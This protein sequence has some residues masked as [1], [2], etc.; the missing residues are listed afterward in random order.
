VPLLTCGIATWAVFALLAA[1]RRSRGLA[2]AAAG[3]GVLIAFGILAFGR[4]DPEAETTTL[5]E[6]LGGLAWLATMLGGATHGAVLLIRSRV[7]RNR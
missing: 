6:D 5:L 1:F 4:G 2:V 3:Y 7:A